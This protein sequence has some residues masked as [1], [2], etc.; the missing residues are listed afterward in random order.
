MLGARG[1]DL[2]SRVCSDF[3]RAEV[4]AYELRVYIYIYMYTHIY[5]LLFVFAFFDPLEWT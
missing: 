4:P 2:G 3:S 1:Y 5:M